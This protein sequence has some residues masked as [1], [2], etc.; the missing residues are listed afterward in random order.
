MKGYKAFGPGMVCRGKQYAENTSFEEPVAELCS[1]GMH[2][3]E[4]PLDTL[5]FYDLVD[6][7]GNITE[8]AEVAAPDECVKSD[9][10][11]AVTTKLDIGAKISLKG[12][13]EASISFIL[14]K[15]SASDKRVACSDVD[16]AQLASSGYGAQLASSGNDA[17]LALNGENGVGAAIGWGS[18]IKGAIGCWITLAEYN[19]DGGCICVKSA[20]IDGKT[21]LPDVWYKLENGNFVEVSDD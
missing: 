21:V 1:S 13:I 16:G 18:A 8:F 10:V 15:T 14:R 6:S 20:R 11:K 5:E 2:F 19:E 9:K 4:N 3:C 17:Q 12:F 7:G